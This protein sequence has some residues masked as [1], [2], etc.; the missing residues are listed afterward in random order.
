VIDLST[1]RV[2]SVRRGFVFRVKIGEYEV[3]LDG[4]HDEVLKTL[5]ELP[6]LMRRINAAFEE[7][8]PKRTTTLTVKT[9]PAPA[10][11]APPAQKYPVIPRTKSCSEAV[12]RILETDWGKWRPRTLSELKETLKVNKLRYPQRTLAGTI[13]GLVNKGKIRRWKTD[14]GYVYILAEEEKLA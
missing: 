3:E 10:K 1:K 5:Q 11:R 9:T 12:L 8:K 13:A 7:V 2:R 14:A 4:T 6:S